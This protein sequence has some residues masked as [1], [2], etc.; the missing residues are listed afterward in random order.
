MTGGVA[1]TGHPIR[2]SIMDSF[3]ATRPEIRHCVPQIPDSTIIRRHRG[4]DVQVLTFYIVKQHLRLTSS[5][6]IPHEKFNCLRPCTLQFFKD[7]SRLYHL[8]ESPIL[9]AREHTD[10][11]GCILVTLLPVQH[12]LIGVKAV[13]PLRLILVNTKFI[14]TILSYRQIKQ[15]D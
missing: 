3:C 15:V 14:H 11:S 1:S 2:C 12:S 13:S 7:A 4:H 6:D 5:P 8:L 10:R 9:R